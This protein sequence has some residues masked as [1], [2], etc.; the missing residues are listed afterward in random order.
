MLLVSGLFIVTLVLVI[1][2]F[3]TRRPK[4]LNRPDLDE[5]PYPDRENDRRAALRRASSIR[6]SFPGSDDLDDI[7]TIGGA[8]Q[9]R[10]AAK[11]QVTRTG[12]IYVPPSDPTPAPQLDN[13]IQL[14]VAVATEPPPAVHHHAPAPA[15]APE[16]CH[17]PSH[18]TSSHHSPSVDTHCHTSSSDFGGGFDGGGHHG[19]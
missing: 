12:T 1:A 10:M 15:P 6:P 14:P 5:D 11:R 9:A 4:P 3:S 17:T 16:P 7:P 13:L 18:D 19:H 8:N 2:V